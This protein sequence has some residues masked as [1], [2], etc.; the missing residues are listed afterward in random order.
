VSDVVAA[1]RLI[2]HGIRIVA[3]TATAVGGR[4]RRHPTAGRRRRSAGTCKSGGTSRTSWTRHGVQASSPCVQQSKSDHVALEIK[5]FALAE[6]AAVERNGLLRFLTRFKAIQRTPANCLTLQRESALVISRDNAE[7]SGT[8]TDPFRF[9]SS[10]N[11]C[12]WYS[13]RSR[14]VRVQ[15]R[16]GPTP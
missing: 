13:S 5:L 12:C 1:R 4:M 7:E 16:C 15:P 10:H 8:M 11:A 9:H 3:M 14:C 2:A 6:A